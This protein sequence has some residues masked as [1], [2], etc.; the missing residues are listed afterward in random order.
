MSIAVINEDYGRMIDLILSADG[1]KRAFF[2]KGS[3]AWIESIDDEFMRAG[4]EALSNMQLHI[5]EALLFRNIS[6]NDVSKELN[7]VPEEI[8]DEIRAIRRILLK[9]I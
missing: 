6:I 9:Y 7:A 8:M 1:V 4:L 2:Y 3:R 5:I